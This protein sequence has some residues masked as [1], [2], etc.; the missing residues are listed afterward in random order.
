M[1][2]IRNLIGNKILAM[3]SKVDSNDRCITL[4]MVKYQKF[5]I[6]AKTKK[7]STV[8]VW[9]TGKEVLVADGEH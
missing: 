8:K 3:N 1:F 7:W 4:F 6:C 5:I 9:H 2:I